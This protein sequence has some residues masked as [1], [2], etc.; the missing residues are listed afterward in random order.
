ITQTL[1]GGVAIGRQ[2]T[3]NLRNTGYFNDTATAVTTPVSAPTVAIPVT[4]RPS[5]TD[6]NNHSRATSISLY[7]QSQIVFS[8]HWQAVLGA[9][10]E[11]FDVDFYDRRTNQSL[12]RT[13]DL[14]APRAALLFKPAEAVTFYTSYSM[15]ALPSSGDQFSSLTATSETLEPEKFKNYEIGAKWDIL[16]RLSL[17]SAVYRL[18]RTN[19]TAPDPSDPTRTVQTGSQRTKGF[20]LSVTGAITPAWQIIGG[21]TNQ[22]ATVNSQTTAA[23]VGARV[24]LVPR[25]TFSLWNRYQVA[26]SLGFG[27]GLIYQD[28]MYAAIDDAV[29]LP[30]FTRVDAGGYYTIAR[31]LR[32]QVNVENLFDT[33]YYATAHSNNNISPGSPRAARVAVVT[34]F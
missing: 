14:I 2:I 16:D 19:T 27:L 10:Y 9:R 7:G 13:D 32:V 3:D 4:F 24:P 25:N 18:D 20:E 22:T 12:S 29:T 23:P 8:E 21:Y 17:A 28:E 6:A 34:D 26:A 33:E 31:Y 1:L 11:H 15:S 5:A 30:S